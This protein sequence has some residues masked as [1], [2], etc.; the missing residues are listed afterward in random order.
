MAHGTT[1]LCV[2][3]F[4]VALLGVV[5][6]SSSPVGCT[7]SRSCT[8][9]NSEPGAGLAGA[10]GVPGGG[11]EA[12]PL[13]S[14]CDPVTEDC[15]DGRLVYV[16]RFG[17][18]S[19]LGTR[20]D[21]VSSITRGLELAALELEAGNAVSL[22]VCSTGGDYEEDIV[23]GPEHAGVA[24][25][26]GYSCTDFSRTDELTV[27]AATSSTGHSIRR[28]S[29]ALLA[30]LV[31][32]APDGEAPGTSSV[33][34]R[35]VEAHG[36][37]IARCDLRAGL[38]ASG[39]SGTTHEASA[40]SGVDGND[41]ANACTTTQAVRAASVGTACGG[42]VTES[43]GG[44]GGCYLCTGATGAGTPST[45]GGG[46]P[47][48]DVGAT[49]CTSGG[50]GAPGASGEHGQAAR[51]MGALD[52]N[53][54]AASAGSS[55]APGGVGQGGGGGGGGLS[56]SC[57]GVNNNRAGGGSGGSGGCGGRGG[58]GGQSGGGS[59]ALLAV[60]S[61]LELD[62]V[63]LRVKTGGAAGAGGDRQLGGSGGLPGE[64]GTATSSGNLPLPPWGCDGGAG[65]PGGSGGSGGG[66]AGG[67]S[68]GVGSKDSVVIRR[69]ATILLPSEPAPGAAGGVGNEDAAGEAGLVTERYDF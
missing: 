69:A 55:G 53:G 37:R 41:G 31:L 13:I 3:A 44:A 45:P 23:L 7:E 40:N 25:V 43:S 62:E 60:R 21:P 39:A 57:S 24:I 15:T 30:D 5:A 63:I 33:A 9:R 11:S 67:P 2:G 26:G 22:R 19:G 68:V 59:F 8:A 12:S 48:E 18:V 29:G 65:G 64:G 49:A 35:V 10:P 38:G 14:S 36:L 28:A 50:P 46:E 27:V 1:M 47:G 61:S 6:C 32:R 42:E 16:S 56:G 52:T 51:R 54:Y 66:G 34:L 17:A 4:S 58:G 20:Q